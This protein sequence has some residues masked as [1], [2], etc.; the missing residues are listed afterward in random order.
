LPPHNSEMND[1]KVDR[2][3]TL[4]AWNGDVALAY[5]VVGEGS[6]DLVY[7]QGWTS[8]I[9]LAWESP[10]LSAFLRGLSRL[11]RLIL[12]TSVVE[13]VPSASR[14]MMFRPSRR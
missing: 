12:R 2:P 9:D 5:Q 14:R 13:D 8:N 1:A 6:I 7:L 3:E 11:G 10:Y 4:Y